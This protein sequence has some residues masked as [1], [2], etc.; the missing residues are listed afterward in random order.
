MLVSAG[1]HYVGATQPHP[2][3]YHTKTGLAGVRKRFTVKP[4][5]INKVW[6]REFKEF[7]HNW[8]RSNL[9]PLRNDCDTSVETWLLSTSYPLWRREQLLSVYM[10]MIEQ[11]GPATIRKLYNN[12]SFGKKETYAEYKH[13]RAINSRSD[14]FKTIVGPIFRLIEKEVF[15]REEF[16]KKIPVAERPAYIRQLLERNGGIY[17][18]TDYTAFESLFVEELLEACEFQLYDYMTSALPDHNEFMRTIR[19]AMLGSNVCEFKNFK[20]K[21]D[22]TRMSGEMCTSL[23]NSFSNLM[24][25]LFVSKKVGCTNVKAVIEGD[26]GLS[27]MTGKPPTADDFAQLGLVIKLVQFDNYYDASFCG[28]IFDPQDMINVCDPIKAVINFGWIKDDYLTSKR[29][30]LLALLRAKSMSL[31]AQYPG[32]PVLQEM[33]MYGMR[34]TSKYDLSMRKWI[35]ESRMSEYEREKFLSAL[36]YYDYKFVKQETPLATRFLMERMFGLSV[37]QQYE[38]EKVFSLKRDLRAFSFDFVDLGNKDCVD[39]FSN[40]VVTRQRFDKNLAYPSEHWSIK[41]K[42]E[43]DF[44][45]TGVWVDSLSRPTR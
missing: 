21:V 17:L 25:L 10:E 22:A 44:P 35:H 2:D 38:I 27:V 3:V 5:T 37:E 30:K 9:T 33:G 39:Y 24:F 7:V 15:A 34:V 32:C 18:Q 36:Y 42:P 12:S 11:G 43:F 1:P 16:I 19:S 26:D 31:L 14:A 13:F 41:F 23:G 45:E 4:P 29:S 40:Y 6:L 20:V 28:L 8:I